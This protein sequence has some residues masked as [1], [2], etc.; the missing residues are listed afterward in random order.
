MLLSLL[1]EISAITLWFPVILKY[2]G[3]IK[4]DW[5]FIG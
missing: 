2:F 1:I 3:L 5:G 4:K